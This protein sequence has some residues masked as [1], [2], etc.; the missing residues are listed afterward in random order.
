MADFTAK[1]G[2]AGALTWNDTLT[3]SNGTAVN[4]SGATVTLAVRTFDSATVL[5][6]SA[7]T[8]VSAPAGTVSYTPTAVNTALP[9]NYVGSWI[10]TFGGGIVQ[11]FPTVGYLEIVVE[12]SVTAPGSQTIVSLEE[13]KEHLNILPTD[14]S[15]DAKIL[16]WIYGMVS[17]IENYVGPVVPKTY[18]E[19]RDGGQYHVIPWHRPITQL[20]ACSFYIGPQEY[21]CTVVGNPAAGTIYSVMLDPDPPYARRIVRRGPGGGI[22]PFPSNLSSIHYV[23][24]AGM[25]AVTDNVKLAMKELVKL[26]YQPSQQA[27]RRARSAGS[28]DF[29]PSV[30]VG[31]L[32]PGKV[33]D[34]LAGDRR[35]PSLA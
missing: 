31:Y 8:V 11:T 2:D 34:I 33:R 9:G 3:Y 28:D 1:Q 10:V 13:V 18:N 14:R 29:I 35:F 21:Q 5:F 20:L 16:S 17:A 6:N 30:P 27:N 25:Y 19:W 22:I 12:P 4:L 32:I 24:Q 26:H 7:A 23:Y 15:H